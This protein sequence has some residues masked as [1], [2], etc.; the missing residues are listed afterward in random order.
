[1]LAGL[2]KRVPIVVRSVPEVSVTGELMT[3]FQMHFL[4][5]LDYERLIIERIVS[6]HNSKKIWY[7]R[8]V[9]INT[10]MTPLL[11]ILEFP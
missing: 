11:K 6:A 3:Y 4:V 5:I 10:I 7:G 2:K 1:M 8:S 9:S